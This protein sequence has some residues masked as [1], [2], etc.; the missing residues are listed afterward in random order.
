MH[1]VLRVDDPEFF[2]SHS[3]DLSTPFEVLRSVQNIFRHTGGEAV[4]PFIFLPYL[5]F[6]G[7]FL[8]LAF[9]LGGSG[10][11]YGPIGGIIGASL[12]Y[13]LARGG[14]FLLTRLLLARLSLTHSL[15][16]AISAGHYQAA[17]DRVERLLTL[18]IETDPAR[19]ARFRSWRAGIRL[20]DL[21]LAQYYSMP[22]PVQAADLLGALGLIHEALSQP[23]AAMV[24]Y[25]RA[26]TFFPDHS[27]LVYLTLGLL[28]RHPDLDFDRR[29]LL[30]SLRSIQRQRHH[31]VRFI[32]LLYHDLLLRLFPELRGQDQASPPAPPQLPFSENSETALPS[33]PARAGVN[34]PN[35]SLRLIENPGEP[36]Q[37]GLLVVEGESV[38]VVRLAPML[39]QFVRYLAATMRQESHLPHF[40]EQRG[41]VSMPELVKNLPGLDAQADPDLIPRLATKLREQLKEAG[42]HQELLEQNPSGSF[43]LAAAPSQIVLEP[44]PSARI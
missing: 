27:F 21:L 1:S 25:Q 14:G 16:H 19:I 29:V 5:H 18:K 30:Q 4:P 6:L 42:V 36:I 41:W 39:F 37:S 11:L 15:A 43:R 26:L 8:G 17:L 28:E 32:F 24:R 31:Y 35:Y 9:G 7:A 40:P 33:A 22:F 20:R 2:L 3:F 38:C 13:C 44:N 10:R 23:Q 12:G 34:S